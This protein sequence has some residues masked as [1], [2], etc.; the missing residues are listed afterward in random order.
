MGRFSTSKA[1][2]ESL[3]M[4]LFP[5]SEASSFG[6]PSVGRLPPVEAG[7]SKN[8]S[9]DSR[10][11]HCSPA[12]HCCPAGPSQRCSPAWQ[13]GRLAGP[14]QHLCPAMPPPKPSKSMRSPRS[15][16]P[17]MESNCS[18]DAFLDLKHHDSSNEEFGATEKQRSS[19]KIVICVGGKKLSASEDVAEEKAA[20][21]G[22]E[23]QVNEAREEEE[24]VQEK[25]NLVPRKPEGKCIT[26]E[27][28]E[29]KWP[30]GSP[31]R[32]TPNKKHAKK[33]KRMKL[34]VALSRREI[35]EDM[36][37]MTGSRLSRKPKKRP[38][39]LQD[40]VDH[41]SPAFSLQTVTP[42]LYNSRV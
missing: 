42:S 11:Q 20:G 21:E 17:K 1:A 22:E 8:R 33:E 30:Q 39:K 36:F 10:S 15:F 2:S 4:K 32:R 27:G 34:S 6:S 14:S 18:S 12:G 13:H 5:I 9:T 40:T 3:S 28:K 23:E 19:S 7:S 38:K 16:S 31:S 26:G 24:Q 37:A 25:W 41:L 29:P 35:E